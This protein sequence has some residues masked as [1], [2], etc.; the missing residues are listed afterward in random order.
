MDVGSNPM[1]RYS[2]CH[3]SFSCGFVERQLDSAGERTG[4]SGYFHPSRKAIVTFGTQ[5]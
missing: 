4:P 2:A 5:H 3:P 1:L